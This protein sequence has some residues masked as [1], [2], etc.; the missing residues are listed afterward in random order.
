MVTKNG[1]FSY[2]ARGGSERILDVMNNDF[3]WSHLPCSFLNENTAFMIL[4]AIM[5]NIFNYIVEKFSKVFNGIKATMRM[6]RFTFR[7][8]SVAGK[9][10]YSGR[11]WILKLYTD[12]NYGGIVT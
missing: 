9:W 8:I 3:G 6:K 12:R 10:V 4:T 7:F 1:I 5:K 11:Q 2:N